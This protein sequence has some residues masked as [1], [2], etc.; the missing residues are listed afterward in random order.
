MK[1]EKKR[2]GEG[3]FL[4]G[5]NCKG[6]DLHSYHFDNHS[7]GGVNVYLSLESLLGGKRVRIRKSLHHNRGIK[8]LNTLGENYKERVWKIKL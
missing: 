8:V 7:M 3:A 2:P 6:G 4:I 1:T 5:D